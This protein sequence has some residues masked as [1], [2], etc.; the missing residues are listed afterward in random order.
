M[1]AE[2]TFIHQLYQKYYA[3]RVEVKPREVCIRCGK[4]GILGVRRPYE[5]LCKK[6]RKSE[7]KGG[8]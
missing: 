6:C 5:G 1:S 8:V 3:N 4:K 2:K 7:W